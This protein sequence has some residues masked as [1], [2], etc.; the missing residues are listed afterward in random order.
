MNTGCI[1]QVEE[2][3]ELIQALRKLDKMKGKGDLGL[4]LR[5]SCNPIV[6]LVYI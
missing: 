1:I 2:L 3:R 4:D 6:C 5:A